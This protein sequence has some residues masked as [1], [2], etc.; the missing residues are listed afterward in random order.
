MAE[1]LLALLHGFEAF[2]ERLRR[3]R[4]GVLQARRLP[5]SRYRKI[6]VRAVLDHRVTEDAKRERIAPI[7]DAAEDTGLS[8]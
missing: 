8:S 1:H 2:G 5:H 7:L 3:G 4:N 6:P